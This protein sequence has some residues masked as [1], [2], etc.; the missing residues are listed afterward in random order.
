MTAAWWPGSALAYDSEST[1]PEPTTARLVTAH[2]VEVSAGGAV[3]RGA[4]LMN[5]GCEIPAE[6]VAIHGVTTEQAQLEGEAPEVVVPAIVTVISCAWAAGLPLVAFNASY[7]L[8]LLEHERSLLGRG[9]IDL[10]P[11][12]DPFVIDHGVERYRKG[13][14]TLTALAEHYNVPQ[15]DAHTAA[16]DAIT[17]ARIAWRQAQRCTELKHL[18]LAELQAWQAKVN[19]ERAA[20][21]QEY[22][23][24]N[25][26]P[27]AVC[28]GEWPVRRLAA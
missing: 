21:L 7:D 24:S 22:F 18:T 14:R 8:T 26:K 11:V 27:D 5:P 19:A 9:P 2:A 28:N 15:G 17:A 10:G 13:K 1:G 3:V 20:H 23:R 25:G 4:W 6:A 16:G 12:I